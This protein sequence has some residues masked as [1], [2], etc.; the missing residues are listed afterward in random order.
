MANYR[1]RGRVVDRSSGDGVPAI[2]VE[3]WDKD[4]FYD[5]LV[6]GDRSDASGAFEIQFSTS[7]FQEL[8]GD[9]KPDLYFKAFAGDALLLSTED[10]VVWNV[11]DDLSDVRLEVERPAASRQ[12]LPS[13]MPTYV[14][15]FNLNVTGR[16]AESF[17]VQALRQWPPL[18]DQVP[19]VQGTLL[20]A[21]ALG[22]AGEYAYAWVVDLDSF[23][24]LAAI[25]K[26]LTSDDK[27]WQSA[28]AT[29]FKHRTDVRARVLSSEGDSGYL[30][31]ANEGSAPGVHYVLAYGA[32]ERSAQASKEAAQSS[33]RAGAVRHATTV[34]GPAD[35]APHEVWV[36]L[37]GLDALGDA[38]QAFDRTAVAG[39][40][41][42]GELRERDG[43][44]L[45]GA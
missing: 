5:D 26:A 23:D 7:Y 41:L 27:R 34:V 15:E 33:K 24:A 28:R 12:R 35:G 39:S 21:N 31:K 4:A 16:E 13:T 17:L 40:R 14:A 37:P 22:L 20:L 38:H 8:F 36:R 43:A 19:G 45:A 1:V 42:Y 9:R 44:L 29:W 3:A 11:E 25:D 30:S 18:Y 10:R 2:R 32:D 6:G